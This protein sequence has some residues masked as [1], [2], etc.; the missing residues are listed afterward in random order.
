MEAN[1]WRYVLTYAKFKLTYHKILRGL[2]PPAKK[3][4][5]LISQITEKDRQQEF[6]NCREEHRQSA[7][8]HN[9]G[10]GARDAR[11]LAG[12]DFKEIHSGF[13]KVDG[14]WR[15]LQYYISFRKQYTIPDRA[16]PAD[17]ISRVPFYIPKLSRQVYTLLT[18]IQADDTEVNYGLNYLPLD[19]PF[20][21]WEE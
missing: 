2:Y 1:Q 13:I 11:P 17:S 14:V 12:L 5:E 6:D 8:K 18:R 21:N 19:R 7:I 9:Y 16:R 3:L 4:Q 20:T 10:E 15:D